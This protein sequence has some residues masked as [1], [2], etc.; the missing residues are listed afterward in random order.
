MKKKILIWLIIIICIIAGTIMTASAVIQRN[1]TKLAQ[2]DIP[3]VNLA[4]ISDG[5]YQGSYSVFPVS[6]VVKVTVEN[7]KIIHIEL[8]K[9]FNGQGTPAEIILSKV[10]ESQSL[11]VDIISGATYSSKVILKAIEN[12]LS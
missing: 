4:E 11:N 5:D 2:D 10:E 7:Y 3:D 1:L 9:H 8:I 6:V 12:A